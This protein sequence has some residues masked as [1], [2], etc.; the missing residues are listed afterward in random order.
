MKALKQL[1]KRRYLAQIIITC[2]AFMLIPS[3]IF[4]YA[5]IFRSYNELSGANED[6]CKNTTNSFAKYFQVQMAEIQTNA[7]M[8]GEDS[9]EA[10]SPLKL[11]TLKSS[12]YYFMECVDLLLQYSI[13]SKYPMGIY[14]YDTGYLFTKDTNYTKETFIKWHLKIEDEKE[15]QD[16]Q[17][18]FTYDPQKSFK[19]FST[20]SSFSSDHL[21]LVGVTIKIGNTQDKAL[22][23]YMLDSSSIDTSLFASQS[24][25]GTQYYVIDSNSY[26][27]LYTTAPRQSQSITIDEIQVLLE[28]CTNGAARFENGDK[29]FNAYVVQDSAFDRDYIALMPYDII[30]NNIY[31][32]YVTMRNMAFAASIVF[33]FLLCIMLYINYRP[34]QKIMGKLNNNSHCNELKAISSTFDEMSNEMSE[35]NLLIMDFL[36]NSILR[37]TPIPANEKDRLG[38]SSHIGN[39]CVCTVEGLELSNDQRSTLTCEITD[40]FDITAYITDIFGIDRNVIILLLENEETGRI[41]SYIESKLSSCFNKTLKINVGIIVKSIDDIQKSYASCIIGNNPAGITDISPDLYKQAADSIKRENKKSSRKINLLKDKVI[42]YMQQ[43]FT[44]P[45]ISQISVANHFGVS[46][47]TL[48]RLF[49]NHIGLGFS[50]YITAKRLEYAKKLLLTTDKSVTEISNEIGIPNVNYFSRL[51]KSNIG[52]SPLKFRSSMGNISGLQ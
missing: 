52:V 2:T 48:S 4:S 12:P 17:Y 24:S 35:Q 10:N 18:F 34:I 8:V 32:F 23:F 19:L 25:S 44:D 38:I 27:L 42:E 15:I 9:K 11:S 40:R 16:L 49:K 20:F 26:T 37:G 31:Q 1:I 6:Y 22:V 7:F 33:L 41:I 43:N 3:I 39:F 50:E 45:G 30:E 28:N 47:Y 13:T 36:L 5:I 21:L 14:Y 29:R 46:I 51:L